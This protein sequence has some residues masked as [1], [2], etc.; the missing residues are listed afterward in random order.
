M[1]QRIEVTL[2]RKGKIIIP[3]D[4][5]NFFPEDY[6]DFTINDETV[7]VVPP[8]DEPHIHL[9][10]AEWFK[11]HPELK[12]GNKLVIEVIELGRRY[13]VKLPKGVKG[14]V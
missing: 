3:R 2:T 13:M 4:K 10:K 8:H 12:A 7:H 6:K 5:R 9:S 11:A 1:S 14:G